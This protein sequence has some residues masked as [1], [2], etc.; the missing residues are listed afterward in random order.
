MQ[1]SVKEAIQ[2]IVCNAKNLEI[3]SAVVMKG[4]NGE[5]ITGQPEVNDEKEELTVKLGE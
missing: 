5:E 3:Q 1:V 2:S 4:E